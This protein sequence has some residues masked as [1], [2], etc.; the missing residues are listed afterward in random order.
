MLC[1]LAVIVVLVLVW[2]VSRVDAK[3]ALSFLEHS[4]LFFEPEPERESPVQAQT[5]PRG[6]IESRRL[7]AGKRPYISPL[8]KKRVAANQSWRCAV[9]QHL[10]DETYEID[11]VTPLWRGGHATN[12]SNLQALCK[13]CHMFKS[14]VSDRA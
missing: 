2:L 9:C 12:E 4:Q 10:L 7:S 3:A 1:T 8:I 13:R 14:A 6:S 5:P 11:H